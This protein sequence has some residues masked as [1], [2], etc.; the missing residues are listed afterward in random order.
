MRIENLETKKIKVGWIYVMSNPDIPGLIKVGYTTTSI[1]KRARELA[2]TGV[3]RAFQVKYSLQVAEPYNVEKKVHQKLNKHHHG[4]EW[5]KCN[6]TEAITVIKEVV[7]NKTLLEQAASVKKQEEALYVEYCKNFISIR[8][9]LERKIILELTYKYD[10]ELHIARSQAPRS[11]F[12][13]IFG[14][15][16]LEKS[17]EYQNLF[18]SKS[19]KLQL[20]KEF[21]QSSLQPCT[22]HQFS[23]APDLSMYRNN[24]IVCEFYLSSWKMRRNCN[25][26]V[27][28]NWR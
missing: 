5:F 12:L 1:E 19:R 8:S 13:G 25:R 4:K 7:G 22:Q 16:Q 18:T 2:G 9:E 24:K 28:K 10:R 17:L 14:E 15:P 20:A 23:N 21:L 3:P 6:V 11:G 27:T 26:K